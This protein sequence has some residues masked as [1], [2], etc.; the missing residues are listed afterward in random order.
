M[1]HLGL[2]FI[3]FCTFNSYSQTVKEA[4]VYPTNLEENMYYEK[5][6]PATS[7]ISG[8]YFMVLCDGDNSLDVTPAFEVSLYLIPQGSS[9]ASDVVI[10]KTYQLDGIYHMGS[11]EFKNESVNIA[12]AGIKAGIYRLGLWVNSNNAFT[13]DGSDNAVLF[14]GPITIGEPQSQNSSDEGW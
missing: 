14:Q 12:N 4:N 13:E 9:N 3:A 10:I 7:T 1:K 8:I 2:I 6:D 5:Y 11:R